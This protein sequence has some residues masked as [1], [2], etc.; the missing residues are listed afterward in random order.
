MEP[1]RPEGG[2]PAGTEPLRAGPV[3]LLVNPTA[4]RGAGRQAGRR[5]LGALR[6]LGHDV[7][8]LSGRDV[9]EARERLAR[10]AGDLAAVVVVG[11]DGLV[12]A[13]VQAVAGTP[14]AL[15]VVPAGTGN[16]LARGL[17]VPLRQPVRAVERLSA[18]LESGRARAVDA[19]HVTGDDPGGSGSGRWFASIL[20][21]GVDARVNARANRW[22]WPTGPS[23]Y[24]LAALRELAVV[25]PVGLRVVLE[26]VPD[27]G[28]R[29]DGVRVLER[30]TL[31]VAVANTRCYGGG[32]LMA[33]HADPT[34]GLLDVVVI[35]ALSPL[36]A[37]TVF[38][39]LRSG[40]HLR[41]PAV[42]VHRAHR[43]HLRPLPGASVPH[44]HADGEA[45]LPL[46]LT[47]T[48]HPGALRVLG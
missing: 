23:R 8:D 31:L 39:L 35:D 17:G 15:G 29:G 6:R 26:G 9:A 16:D 7:E 43:V 5:A 27:G 12:H 11:G 25:R 19:V 36:A 46:P 40:R 44:P 2:P 13:A 3:G 34:D 42:H 1:N 22:R 28:D 14:T 18:A 38:P 37:L 24:T 30:P 48:A 10:R 20:G 32:L 4:G 33:P 41:H 45:A 47:C 21:A